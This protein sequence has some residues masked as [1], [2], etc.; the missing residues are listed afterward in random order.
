MPQEINRERSVLERKNKSI[1]ISEF[2][3]PLLVANVP[4]E[5]IEQ[6]ISSEIEDLRK[7]QNE[8]TNE[9]EKDSYTSLIKNR[10][11]I[12]EEITKRKNLNIA[13]EKFD[14]VNQ[15][16]KAS[17]EKT[18]NLCEDLFGY[19][20][21][22]DVE[23]ISDFYKVRKALNEK[24][25]TLSGQLVLQ[26]NKKDDVKKALEAISD[27]KPNYKIIETCHK[28]VATPLYKNYDWVKEQYKNGL[29]KIQ[30]LESKN[31][32]LNY[33]NDK[34]KCAELIGKINNTINNDL[35]VVLE[36]PNDIEI[37]KKEV[38]KELGLKLETKEPTPKKETKTPG[39]TE[40]NGDTSAEKD[41]KK[42]IKQEAPSV[43]AQPEITPITPAKTKGSEDFEKAK[44]EYLNT[45]NLINKN[46]AE[47]EVINGEQDMFTFNPEENL[48]NMIAKE[49]AAQEITK[50]IS[51]LKSYLLE[52]EYEKFINSQIVLVL[53]EEVKNAKINNIVHNSQ[54]ED[55]IEQHNA[56]IAMCYEKLRELAKKDYKNDPKV[57]AE[58]KK[59]QDIISV[60]HMII[61][62][63]IVEERK[64]NKDFDAIKFMREHTVKVSPVKVE[65][66]EV[67]PKQTVQDDKTVQPKQTQTDDMSKYN[68]ISNLI[69]EY[70][71]DFLKLYIQLHYLNAEIGL[72]NASRAQLIE[73]EE[74]TAQEIK[75]MRTIISEKILTSN[76]SL[77][78]KINLDGEFIKTTNDV[79]RTIQNLFANE[80]AHQRLVELKKDVTKLLTKA[81]EL[82][83]LSEQEDKAEEYKTALA[84]F[85]GVLDGLKVK[86]KDLE[87]NVTKS[88]SKIRIEYK[89]NSA[90]TK[91]CD[92]EI[93]S[94]KTIKK[95]ENE[96]QVKEVR[97]TIKTNALKFGDIV[98]D[99]DRKASLIETVKEIKVTLLKQK[100][101]IEYT[102]KL[103][104]D[105]KKLKVKLEVQASAEN[106]TKLAV[107]NAKETKDK[108]K[109][110]RHIDNIED[111]ST[112]QLIYRDEATDEEIMSYD[113][114]NDPEIQNELSSRKSMR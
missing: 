15:E 22:L 27:L 87:L 67:Q 72:N 28:M 107:S 51:D 42:T 6:V 5:T 9:E 39:N 66:P 50:R 108:K 55:F 26:S 77:E 58:V 62:R 97:T 24:I 102:K 17:Y 76:L 41:D 114:L 59:Y 54:L 86:Y 21:S 85:N 11:L 80:K 81:E 14:K 109:E 84:K 32:K 36:N 78:N 40:N 103:V 90:D 113:L 111:I 20:S 34:N 49:Q 101:K 61:T 23:N 92:I 106:N 10:E 33:Q 100:L 91:A 98:Q 3:E 46:I 16:L 1:M 8:T 60:Q 110:Y 112:A 64:N 94:K 45:V 95:V 99:T 7:K 69:K 57:Q 47:L 89:A 52:L 88:E 35:V 74:K 19:I 75:R 31:T 93:K 68:Y 71:D 53:D 65:T 83:K 105:L 104:E 25:G 48:E 13:M 96:K 63:R 30:E 73:I 4:L 12:L 79:E 56:V 37:I 70:K 18:I 2:L 44:I 43:E 38:F 82:V 29:I